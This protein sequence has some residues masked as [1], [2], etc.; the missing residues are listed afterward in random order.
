MSEEEKQDFRSTRQELSFEMTIAHYEY[1]KD[2][3]LHV[4]QDFCDAYRVRD[5]Q[6]K[7]TNEEVL[8]DRHLLKAD[9]DKTKPFNSLVLMAANDPR[10]TIAGCRVRVQRFGTLVEG[11]GEGYSPLR[12]RYVEGNLVKVMQEASEIISELVYDV[13]WLNAEG[14]FVT[15]PEYPRWAWYEA[16]INACVHRSYSYS[17][18]EV[19]VKLF[20]DRMEIESPGGFVPPVTEKTIYHTRSARNPHLMDAL[21]YLGYVQMAREGT[22]RI[23]ASM[24]EWELPD[25]IFKQEALHG[26]VVRVTLMNDHETRKR[27]T[28]RDVALHF[29]VE[30]WKTLQEHEV[31]IAAHAF[32]NGAIQVS[33]AQRVTGR[34]W[35]TSKKDLDRLVTK[36][37]LVFEPGRFTR[38][39]KAIYRMAKIVP[40]TP[41]SELGK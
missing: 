18:S 16:L 20:P 4:I 30:L 38:D 17:G 32:R 26:V 11:T 37:M 23:R 39:P 19:T 35:G 8:I 15:T 41:E 9:G 12:D 34:T 28:N 6:E 1:P 40:A 22:R 36:G 7:W 14:K 33:E 27:A 2:F 29:G 25:P 3:D 10:V 5:G 31:K 21:R 24:N 13:T